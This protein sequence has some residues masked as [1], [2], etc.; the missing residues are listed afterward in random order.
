MLLNLPWKEAAEFRTRARE[1]LD[2]LLQLHHKPIMTFIP[3]KNL[4][5]R[6]LWLM[7]MVQFINIWD[8]M[9]VMPLGPDFANRLHIDTSHLGWI[10]GSY[11]IS[12]ALIG[13]VSARFLD[14][15]DRKR[16]LLFN[17]CGL[18]LSTLSMIF[19]RNLTQLIITRIITG[20][21]GGPMGAS[22]LA[23]IADVFPPERRGEAIGKVFG[24]FSIASVIGV[25]LALEIARQFGLRAPFIA[26]SFVAAL[27][28]IAIYRYLPPMRKHLEN[29]AASDISLFDSL[30]HNPATLPA[31]LMTATG[32]FGAF[33]LIPNI[34]AHVQQ[35]MG[36]PR[37]WLGLLYFCGG[38][39]ALITMR[40]VGKISDR[41]GYSITS[42]YATIGL[43]FAITI[44]FYAQVKAVPV[45]II[46]I[47]FMMGM[48]TRNVTINALLT[49]IPKPN[50]RAGFMSLVS[51]MQHLMTGLGALFST[52]LLTETADH[53]LAGIDNL[54]LISMISFAVSAAVMFRIERL[55]V[56]CNIAN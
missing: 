33:I 15:F 18:M 39:A 11:S 44:G 50:E 56:R 52:L 47:L 2:I 24:A 32:L 13:I 1:Q 31:L 45:V 19:A 5:R 7:A 37:A 30:R 25:P 8:F 46:F 35:N 48:S 10:V 36:Y 40:F 14:R 16:V 43:F 38:I 20:L 12:A 6:A 9:I 27:T 51:A 53:K 23:V 28:V 54:A 4:E 42:L 34:S 3:P 29:K 21:F 17:L 22:A 55:I 49:K 26:I 41:I